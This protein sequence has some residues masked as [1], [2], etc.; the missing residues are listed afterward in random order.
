MLH[1]A[2][3]VSFRNFGKGGKCRV[4]AEEGGMLAVP[5]K[6]LKFQMLR[7]RISCHLN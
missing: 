1:H 7:D 3:R 2:I 6:F 5:Q 4:G